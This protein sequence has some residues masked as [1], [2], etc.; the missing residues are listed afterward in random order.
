MRSALDFQYQRQMYMFF[1]FQFS[2]PRMVDSVTSHA[3]VD[4]QHSNRQ[5]EGLHGICLTAALIA[6]LSGRCTIRSPRT[7]PKILRVRQRLAPP[8]LLQLYQLLED[9]R[10]GRIRKGVAYTTHYISQHS[11]R[12]ITCLA[13]PDCVATVLAMASLTADRKLPGCGAMAEMHQ[14]TMQLQHD[15]VS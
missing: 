11:G 10:F 7:Y 5:L 2:V 6:A 13:R 12:R 4:P 14:L 3:V 8:G 15:Q 1:V 9:P